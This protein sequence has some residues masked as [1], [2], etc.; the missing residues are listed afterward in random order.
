[1]PRREVT[2]RS[3]GYDN[4]ADEKNSA[5]TLGQGTDE[6]SGK[7]AP[8]RFTCDEELVFRKHVFTELDDR[9]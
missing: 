7:I 4:R 6:A 8:V 3:I 1:L 5:E 2:P 9:V